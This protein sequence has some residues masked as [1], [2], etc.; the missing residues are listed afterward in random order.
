MV[1]V[2][3]GGVYSNEL[4]FAVIF[5]KRFKQSKDTGLI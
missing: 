2:E 4:L 3:E 1:A 5:G